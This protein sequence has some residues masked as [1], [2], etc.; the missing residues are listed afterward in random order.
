[1]SRNVKSLLAAA[2]V[3]ALAYLLAFLSADARQAQVAKASCR[4]SDSGFILEFKRPDGGN[5]KLNVLNLRPG[6]IR[7]TVKPKLYELQFVT[8]DGAVVNAEKINDG[9]FQKSLQANLIVSSMRLL[10]K[11]EAIT[12][13]DVVI[14]RKPTPAV[15][16]ILFQFIILF[17]LGATGLLAARFLFSLIVKGQR[18]QEQAPGLLLWPLLLLFLAVFLYVV[19]HLCGFLER[20]FRGEPAASFLKAL[21][22]N[23]V[24]ALSLLALFYLLSLRRKG[25][26]LPVYLPILFSLPIWFIRVP[27]SVKASADSLLWVLNL[28]FHKMEISFAEALS[29]LLNKLTF[30]LFNQVTHTKAATSLV[31]TGKL[32]GILFIFSLYLFINSFSNLSYKKKV[33]FFLLVA[34]FSFTVLLFGFPEFRYYSLP[35]LMFSFLAAK[36]YADEDEDSIAW[37]AAATACAVLAGLSHGIAYFSFPVILLLPFLKRPLGGGSKNAAFY[38]RHGSTIILAAGM[39]FAVFI[40]LIRLFGFNLQFNTVAGGFDGRQFIPLLPLDVHYPEAVNFL[41]PGYFFSRGWILLSSGSFVFLLFPGRWKR[42]V[43]LETSDF[44]LFLFGLSQFLIILFWGFDNGVGEFDL[45]MVPPTMMS[46]FLIRYLLAATRS[47]TDSW[48]TIIAFSLC[49]MLLPLFLRVTG[50]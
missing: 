10:P 39:V 50:G 8:Y 5:R 19:S 44:I 46:L 49:S 11:S 35:F 33:L 1:M 28:T 14:T 29:L 20:F 34:T 32:V 27:F 16:F 4:K 38:L 3:L 47:E 21:A 24:L 23:G 13:I 26:R 18:P 30:Y 36:K 37:L 9:L 2:F 48:K 12:R 43:A 40:T 22:F 15:S 31:Y 41:E 6:L 25:E 7:V 42:R 45:Y 17:L